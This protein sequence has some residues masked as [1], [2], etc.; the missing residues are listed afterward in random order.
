MLW[1]L[2]GLKL[3]N[4][5]EGMYK[6]Y[7]PWFVEWDDHRQWHLL[8]VMKPHGANKTRMTPTGIVSGGKGKEYAVRFY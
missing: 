7:N 6:K 4:E 3:F 8:W 1:V 5:A 2:L